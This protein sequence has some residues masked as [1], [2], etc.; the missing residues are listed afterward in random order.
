MREIESINLRNNTF[1]PSDNSV[2]LIWTGIV[3]NTFVTLNGIFFTNVWS[4]IYVIFVSKYCKPEQDNSSLVWNDDIF[5][6]MVYD[7]IKPF[8]R[9]KF[10]LTF[11]FSYKLLKFYIVVCDTSVNY[12]NVF[13]WGWL[14]SNHGE[15]SLWAPR[16]LH[17]VKYHIITKRSSCS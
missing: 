16:K 8:Q 7:N 15:T 4:P 9:F 11:Y 1:N 3:V 6:Q 10:N 5:Y 13:T 14:L 17:K 12:L 2:I